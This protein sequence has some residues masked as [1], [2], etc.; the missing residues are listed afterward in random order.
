MRQINKL[1]MIG[2]LAVAVSVPAM[3]QRV[4]PGA[5]VRKPA[6]TVQALISQVETDPVVADRFMRHFHMSK[7]EVIEYF[8]GLHL[9][10]LKKG[11]SY[12]V[13]N[14]HADGVIRARVFE[15]KEGTLM[16]ADAN[17]KPILK[18][19]C[20]NPL[21]MGEISVVRDERT[22]PAPDVIPVSE[23]EPPEALVAAEV[24]QPPFTPM[25]MEVTPPQP[26]A[27]LEAR[28]MVGGAAGMTFIPLLFFFNKTSKVECCPPVPEPTTMAA[29]AIAPG[30]AYLLRRRRRQKTA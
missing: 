18:K 23:I 30:V 15:L 25:G 2:A 17:G 16:F 21:T 10:K 9:A 8:R 26:F 24:Q 4:E 28:S 22:E 6:H 29:F 13:F 5:F 20:A 12:R 1:T 7:D 19:N 14:V 27:P 3:A 11:G